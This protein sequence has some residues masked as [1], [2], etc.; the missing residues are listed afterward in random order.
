[1]HVCTYTN[2]WFRELYSFVRIFIDTVIS[3][4]CFAFVIVAIL[5][6]DLVKYYFVVI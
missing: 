4:Y 5:L 1:M 2:N 6:L 3:P